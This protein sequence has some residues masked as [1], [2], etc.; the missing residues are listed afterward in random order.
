MI[1]G[2]SFITQLLNIIYKLNKI[3]SLIDDNNDIFIKTA[4]INGFGKCKDIEKA[5]N[6]FDSISFRDT[7]SIN[8]IMTVLNDNYWFKQSQQIY[9]KFESLHKNTSHLL[10]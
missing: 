6:I 3:Y 7:V 1:L 8:A 10:A 4:F 9:N 5:L 2:V